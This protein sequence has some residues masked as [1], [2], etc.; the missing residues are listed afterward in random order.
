MSDGEE[1]IVNDGRTVFPVDR[2]SPLAPS[3]LASELW[4]NLLPVLAVLGPAQNMRDC[5]ES[6]ARHS[7][8]LK[9]S[10]ID[11]QVSPP[12]REAACL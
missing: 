9:P 1:V 8:L 10:S 12:K 11:E 5:L 2:I 4:I 3:C 7:I 6:N